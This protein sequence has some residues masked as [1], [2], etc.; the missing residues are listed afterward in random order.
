MATPMYNAGGGY[1]ARHYHPPGPV[2]GWVDGVGSWFGGGTPQY[3][4][5]GQPSPDDGGMLGTGT[6]T[7]LLGQM[8][9]PQADAVAPMTIV[10]PR[11]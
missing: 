4:G 9:G 3:L 2:W 6:P 10:V 5:N 11:T 1:R 7:Y 8:G